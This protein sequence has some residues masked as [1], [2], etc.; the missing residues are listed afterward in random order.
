LIGN[1][2][3]RKHSLGKGTFG[4]VFLADDLKFDPPRAVAIKILHS[5]FLN[6]AGV[7]HDIAHEASIL[8]RFN[9]PNILRVLD[10]DIT[11]DLAYIVTELAEGGSLAQRIR[12]DPTRPPVRQPLKDVVRYLDQISDALDEAHAQGLIHRDL[13]PLNILLDRRNRPLIADFG[14][15]TAVSN[16]QSSVVIEVN[17]SGTPPYMAPEQWM[18][19]VSRASDNYA[20]GI[21]TY[22]LITGQVPFQGEPAALGF[23]HLNAPIP[24]LSDRAPGLI[25]P[26]ALDEALAGVLA[27]DPRQ[28][29]RPAREF[30]NRFRTALSQSDAMADSSYS[31]PSLPPVPPLTLTGA[32]TL[33]LNPSPSTAGSNSTVDPGSTPTRSVSLSSDEATRASQEQGGSGSNPSGPT[34]SQS[35]GS[36]PQHSQPNTF[37]SSGANFPGHSNSNP[38]SNPPGS[39]PSGTF[40][41]NPPALVCP[42][43]LLARPAQKCP[44]ATWF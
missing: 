44:S 39:I 17:T 3:Q 26:P 19:Q 33:S 11:P 18:G 40:G 21:I 8:A 43:A 10:F 15:A 30:A 24:R 25:Y 37:S 13:K 2:Y 32:D 29:T 7:R 22:Q 5:K 12:P 9:H 16:S 1:R 36:Q 6:E 34:G 41:S 4:E 14:M 38:G 23:Q 42:P 20:L 35:Q 28:R 31:L 27:K